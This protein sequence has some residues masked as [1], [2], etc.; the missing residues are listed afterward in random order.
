[1]RSERFSMLAKGP[2]SATEAECCVAFTA[3]LNRLRNNTSLLP[4]ALK[5]LVHSREVIAALDALRHPKIEFF[6]GA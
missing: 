6:R 4:Q 1:M 3:S 2:P 5:P